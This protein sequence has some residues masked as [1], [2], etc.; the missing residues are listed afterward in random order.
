VTVVERVSRDSDGPTYTYEPTLRCVDPR[1]GYVKDAVLAKW[2][3]RA[4]ADAFTGWLRERLGVREAR[5]A[6]APEACARPAIAQ[7]VRSLLEKRTPGRTE[8]RGG[9]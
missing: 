8:V 3:D 1:A 9:L 2:R 7:V 4:K 5:K 6:P